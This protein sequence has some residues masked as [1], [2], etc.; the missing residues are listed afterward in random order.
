[1]DHDP[2]GLLDGFPEPVHRE[3]GKADI[4]DG[5]VR[6]GVLEDPDDDGFEFYLELASDDRDDRDAEA[7]DLVVDGLLDEPVLRHV[8]L[9]AVRPLRDVLDDGRY[10]VGAEV[11]DGLPEGQQA[12]HAEEDLGPPG[13]LRDDVDIARVQPDGVHEDIVDQ[14]GK[15]PP[16]YLVVQLV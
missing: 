7:D 8:A 6:L 2:G 14:L 10:G 9:E 12:V 3:R 1:E 5:D 15:M 13:R 11:V 16:A 4:V